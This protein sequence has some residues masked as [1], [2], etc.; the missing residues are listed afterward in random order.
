[1]LSDMRD[2]QGKVLARDRAAVDAGLLQSLRTLAYELT[3]AE[4]RE[5][6]RIARGLHDDIGQILAA[7]G[8][9]LNALREAMPEGL[10]SQFNELSALLEQ[11][12]T[13]TR[14]ATFEISSPVLSLGLDQALRSLC[15]KLEVDTAPALEVQGDVGDLDLAE[16]VLSVLY[17]VVRELLLNVLRH[18]HARK[19]W[20]RMGHDGTTL[21]ISVSD[22]GVGISTE[23]AARGLG[24]DGGF[25]LASAH[26][27]MQALGGSLVLESG[28]G[29]GT[30][31]VLS[32]ALSM[33]SES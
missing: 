17:R 19:A 12:A 24:R 28:L 23:S 21:V 6:S 2:R 29:C 30:V 18:A 31:A 32:L 22:D 33:A 14:T 13:A 4:A 25:G 9:K 26:A 27:Q 10:D 8:F 5:R 15:D 11:A 3:V 16:P 1:M 7:A 20:V